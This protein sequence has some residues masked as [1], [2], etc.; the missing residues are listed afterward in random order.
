MHKNRIGHHVKIHRSFRREN[1]NRRTTEN[2]RKIKRIQMIVY[3]YYSKAILVYYL[4]NSVRCIMQK[5]KK[6]SDK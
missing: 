2:K 6:G 1:A 4:I 5:K 3:G